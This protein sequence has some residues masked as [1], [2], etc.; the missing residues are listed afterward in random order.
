MESTDDLFGALYLDQDVPVQL[1]GMLRAHG[2]DV[3]TTLEAA[4]LGASDEDQLSLAVRLNRTIVTHNRLDFERLHV[5][6]LQAGETH[7]GVIIA[8]Q[9]RALG[10]T[11]DR[12]I[13]L[14]N[15]FDREQLANGLYY[16]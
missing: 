15:Q 8:Q 16:V 1:A 9:R 13:Q 12:L 11:R 3:V 10:E 4:M 7:C 2:F 6:A 5:A 14:L